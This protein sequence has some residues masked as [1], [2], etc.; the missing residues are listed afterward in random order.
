M[1]SEKRLKDI[2]DKAEDAFWEVVARELPEIE[3]G[4]FSPEE[5]I[6][7]ES[8]MKKWI[9]LWIKWNTSTDEVM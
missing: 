2:R 9:R 7:M 5:T 1:I 6:R 8:E 3:S 4:D